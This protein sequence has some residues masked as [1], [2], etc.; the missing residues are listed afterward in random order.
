MFYYHILHSV[1]N[2][3]GILHLI[4]IMYRIPC[5]TQAVERGVR[6][7]TEASQ[8]VCSEKARIGF[9]KNRI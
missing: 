5:H 8:S 7:V 4:C 6:L 9:I 1:L 2:L 3:Q